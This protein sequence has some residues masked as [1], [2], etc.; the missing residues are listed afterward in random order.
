MFRRCVCRSGINKIGGVDTAVAREIREG[1]DAYGGHHQLPYKTLR[2]QPS[3]YIKGLK[4]I[5]D[6]EDTRANSTLIFGFSAAFTMGLFFFFE[7]F[8]I[9]GLDPLAAMPV[10]ANAK[11]ARAK[12]DE[13]LWGE[14]VEREEK[15]KHLGSNE[16]DY[17]NDSFP[18][19]ASFVR[20]MNRMTPSAKLYAV[21]PEEGS[22][23]QEPTPAREDASA[24][25]FF[26]KKD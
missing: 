17:V 19:Q 9:P 10:D 20:L 25:R 16:A 7:R 13:I 1:C 11:E 18:S 12:R 2:K 8:V 26:S 15:S 6:M 4:A 14:T 5:R 21:Q 22:G 24:K 23:P 3:W